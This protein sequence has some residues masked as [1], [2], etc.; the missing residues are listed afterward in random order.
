MSDERPMYVLKTYLKNR[1]VKKP[2][3]EIVVNDLIK[4]L[5]SKKFI[6]KKTKITTIGSCFAVRLKE[7]LIKNNYNYINGDWDRVYTPRNIK[8]ILKFSLE[9]DSF[10]PK[11]RYWEYNNTF[12]SPYIKE[13]SNLCKLISKD[14]NSFYDKEKKLSSEYNKVLTESDVI[15]I[16]LGQ[17]ECWSNIGDADYPFFQS[18]HKGIKGISKDLHTYYDLTTNEVK[19]ELQEIYDLLKKH[20]KD[21]KI[22][23]SVSPVPFVGTFSKKYSYF[24]ASNFTKSKLLSSTLEFIEDKEDIFYMPSYEYVNLNPNENFKDDGRH[25]PQKVAD[26]IMKI[27]EKIFTV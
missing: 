2:R 25:V 4:N 24:V 6:D 13:E 21:I 18:P 17:T 22:I 26:K 12:R 15:I 3:K 11:Q 1:W 20:N 7:W 9:Y 27:F 5:Y 19:Q 23:F 8:N 10:N 14:F 16:T